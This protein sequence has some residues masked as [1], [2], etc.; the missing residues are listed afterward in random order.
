LIVSR[1]I[2]RERQSL[3]RELS[4]SFDVVAGL[5]SW[6]RFRTSSFGSAGEAKQE[7]PIHQGK[8]C[9]SDNEVEAKGLEPS[10]LLT[11]SL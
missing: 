2:V 4:T 10:N 9:D 6:S 5:N 8:R 11:A 1:A 7:M 3:I